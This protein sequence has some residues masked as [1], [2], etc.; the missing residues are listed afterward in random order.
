LRISDEAGVLNLNGGNTIISRSYPSLA[1]VSALGIEKQGHWQ[2][3]APMANE[4]FYTNLWHNPYYGF[5]RAV[6]TYQMTDSPRRLK[7]LDIYYHTYS[8]S[9]KA[10]L[11]ALYRIY[12]YALKQPVHIVHASDYIL[13]AR[14]FNRVVV[15]RTAD[16]G[17]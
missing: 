4:N 10:S 13:K 8:A 11:S 14:D 2:T 12:D 15:A 7:P 16:G 1:Y 5:E 17:W 9:K 3:Y 6:E